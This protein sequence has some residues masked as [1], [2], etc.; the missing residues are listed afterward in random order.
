MNKDKSEDIKGGYQAQLPSESKPDFPDHEAT[1]DTCPPESDKK[2]K[3]KELFDRLWGAADELRANSR[4]RSTQYSTPVLG[5]L[6]LRYADYKFRQAAEELKKR[7][8]DS[9]YQIRK[10]DYQASGIIYLTEKD[11][12]EYLLQLTEGANIGKAI[13]DAMRN[14]ENENEELRDVLPRIYTS[15]EDR[16]LINL[17]KIFHIIP[18]ELDRD[19]FGRIYEYFLGKFARSE[20]QRGGEFYTPTSIVRLIVEVLEPYHGRILDPAC[21]SGG[22]FV[23]SAEFVKDHLKS[24]YKEIMVYGQE[25]TE[26]IVRL[27]KMNLAIHGLSGDVRQG[28]SYY[29][30]VF[31]MRGKFDFVMAN[32]PFNVNNVDKEAIRDD[33]RYR[34]GLPSV[35]NA[36]YLWIQIFHSMLNENGRAGF[37]MANSASDTGYSEL[38]IRKKLVQEGA[39]DVVISV[40][41]NFFYTVTLPVTLWFLD[42]GKRSTIKKGRVLF[43]DARRIYKQIDR[44]HRE[45]AP[46]QIEFIS[47]IVRL[48]KGQEME[49]SRCSSSL[50]KEYFPNSVYRD[51]NGLCKIA[52]INEIESQN[53]SLNPGRYVGVAE[54]EKEN[55]DLHDRLQELYEEVE[56]LNSEAQ[57]LEKRVAENMMKLLESMT[58]S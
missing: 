47:N 54:R 23:Q 30:D 32:P 45:F 39:V 28:N 16:V 51:I 22:M 8:T 52:N 20:G 11:R 7:H 9:G 55:Y 1:N 3:L 18:T 38:E 14:I 10:L 13:D 36:N 41:S 4:L 57:E 42:N 44:T 43:M 37:V 49:T 40:A 24:P 25:K 29:E 56:G 33:P 48:S 2:G 15:M 34:L 35:D 27:S 6:F 21:G 50:V 26:D 17:L 58:H 5:I 12:Y 31:N 46:Q 53:W 19:I